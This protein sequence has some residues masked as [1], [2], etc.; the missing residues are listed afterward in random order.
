[1][2]KLY[3]VYKKRK[4]QENNKELKLLISQI[5]NIEKRK[6]ELE[7]T[8]K[9]GT[10]NIITRSE[11]LR[12]ILK[13]PPNVYGLKTDIRLLKLLKQKIDDYITLGE[14]SVN[15]LELLIQ[16]FNKVYMTSPSNTLAQRAAT[17]VREQN[18]VPTAVQSEVL[19]QYPI[20]QNWTPGRRG[21]RSGGRSGGRK[22][23]KNKK[24]RKQRKTRTQ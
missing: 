17:S 10:Q 18:I 6:I 14:N 22:S 8:L 5:P 24:T 12:D 9:T 2:K 3:S 21:G 20:I 16:L 1:M 7:E 4:Q 23:R 11:Y 13:T 15:E 19:E